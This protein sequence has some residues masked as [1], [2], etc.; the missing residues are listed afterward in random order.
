MSPEPSGRL[1]SSMEMALGSMRPHRS[2]CSIRN[3]W[4]VGMCVRVQ[5]DSRALGT[6]RYVLP[7]LL[8]SLQACICVPTSLKRLRTGKE[9]REPVCT[10][11]QP[12]A[13]PCTRGFTASFISPQALRLCPWTVW[14]M[15]TMMMMTIMRS[16]ILLFKTIKGPSYSM[17]SCLIW[18]HKN[19]CCRN[20]NN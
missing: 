5:L 19:P 9:G 4:Q 18:I 17:L 12:R 15:V 2:L 20:G 16:F 7:P 1:G 14:M 10:E 3:W 6:A 11:G 13:G 8:G